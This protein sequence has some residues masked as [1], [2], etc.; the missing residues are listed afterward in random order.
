[1]V[2]VVELGFVKYVVV[3]VVEGDGVEEV[4]WMGVGC[5]EGVVFFCGEVLDDDIGRVDG[6]KGGGDVGKEGGYEVV[7]GEGVGGEGGGVVCFGDFEDE[8]CNGEVG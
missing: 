4:G 3:V 6:G 5:V 1:M 7:G 8:G 2:D